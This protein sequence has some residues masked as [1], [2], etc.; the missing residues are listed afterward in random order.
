MTGKMMT[1]R[2]FTLMCA[3]VVYVLSSPCLGQE[4][5][6]WLKM[7]RKGTGFGYEHIQMKGLENGNFEYRFQSLQKAD[8]AGERPQDHALRGRYIVDSKLRPISFEYRIDFPVK[9]AVISGKKADNGFEMWIEEKGKKIG[10]ERL[11]SLEFYFDVALADLI[12]RHRHED[13]VSL[14]ILNPR[15]REI[16]TVNCK[17]LHQST[18]SVIARIENAITQEYCIDRNGRIQRL[19][20]IELNIHKFAADSADAKNISYLRTDDG[21]S[22]RVESNT[23][24]TNVFDVDRAKIEVQWK[25][26]HPEIFDFL[27]N[28]QSLVTLD[29][30]GGQFKATLKLTK[31]TSKPKPLTVPVGGQQFNPF[32]GDADYIQPGAVSIQN[33]M[34]QIAGEGRDAFQIVADIL[35]WIS[36]NINVD[37]LAETLTATEV[38]A[39]RR[40]KCAEFAILFASLTRAAGIPSRLVLGV[41]NQGSHWIGHL[42]NE[43]WLGEWLAVDPTFGN[44]VSAASHIKFIDSPTLAGTQPLRFKLVD[45]LKVDVLEFTEATGSQSSLVTGVQELCYANQYYQCVIS[46]PDTSWHISASEGA[47]PTVTMMPRHI[48]GARFFLVMFPVPPGAS[49]KKILSSRI[50][51]IKSRVKNFKIVNEEDIQLAGKIAPRIVFEFSHE[52]ND[53][54][55][56]HVVSENCLLIDGV[57]GYLFKF[58]A[59]KELFREFEC[60]SK[61]IKQSFKLLK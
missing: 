45:N 56:V 13:E 2:Q 21:L 1:F 46:A 48:D 36:A 3:L 18:D 12:F 40:G 53:G 22:L 11:A 5:D 38:L 10:Q 37:Y 26:V 15:S 9:K 32:L 35:N 17:I 55:L 8:V 60:F 51:I 4:K 50:N 58:S 25:N 20:L 61:Q 6:Y 42:W 59:E 39:Q 52:E 7:E 30:A 24:F 49:Q 33:Q 54:E 44:F 47:R 43:V 28:R 57:H 31:F 19:D 23:E 27:D 29:S 16:E 34:A 14:K 41:V